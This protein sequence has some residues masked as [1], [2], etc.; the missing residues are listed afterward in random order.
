[1]GTGPLKE[2]SLNVGITVGEFKF[3]PPVILLPED[4]QSSITNEP[5]QTVTSSPKQM[6]CCA[7][8][9]PTAKKQKRAKKY[10]IGF[11]VKFDR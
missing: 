1:M 6:V 5:P 11:I 8:K 9:Y 10:L 3:I 4:E 7:W 2:S